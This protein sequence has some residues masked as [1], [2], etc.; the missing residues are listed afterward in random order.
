MKQSL[1]DKSKSRTSR[2]TVLTLAA[3]LL[4]AAP[5]A[6][7]LPTT[8]YTAQSKLNSDKWVK[9]KTSG[10]GIHEISY[11]TLRQWGFSNPEKVNVY[12]YGATLLAPETF[13]V[14]TPDDIKMTYTL[15]EG[16]KIYFYS[17]GDVTAELTS[18][19]YAT[20]RRNYYSTDVFYLLSDRTPDADEIPSAAAL[21]TSTTTV[22]AHLS[23]QYVEDEL[24]NP[25]LYGGVFFGKNL[26]DDGSPVDLCFETRDMGSGNTAYRT[27][28]IRAGFAVMNSRSTKLRIQP[29]SDLTVSTNNETS[30]IYYFDAYGRYRTGSTYMSYT[31]N[32]TDGV[33]NFKANI[34]TENAHYTPS[35]AAMDYTWFIYPRLSR[36][37]DD[38]QLSM[39]FPNV[40]AVQ[41]FSIAGGS[42]TTR[43][44][45]ISSLTNIRPHATSFDESTGTVTASFDRNYSANYTPAVCHIVAF[46]IDRPQK[47][48]ELVGEIANQ[49]F[50]G[51]E[52]P[53]MLIITVPEL[54]GAAEELAELHRR[55]DG[56]DV[57]VADHHAIFNEFSSATPDIMGYR[58]LIKMFY[59]RDPQ[60]FKYVIMYGTSIWDNRGIILP[61]SDRLLV[62]E[63]LDPVYSGRRTWAFA[64]DSY[65]G[66]LNDNYY[67]DN[68]INTKQDVAVGRIPV[69]NSTDGASYN[70]KVR[71]YLEDRPS[72]SVYNTVLLMSDDGDYNQHLDQSEE[73]AALL[74]SQHQPMTIVR[75]HNSIFPWD[76]TDAK[77]LRSIATA[78]FNRGAGLFIYVGH[79]NETAF[80][81]EALWNRNYTGKTVYNTFPLG[82]W[83]TCDPFA[84][85]LDNDNHGQAALL[86]EDG[87]LVAV[88]AAGRTVYAASNRPLTNSV[89]QQYAVARPGATFGEIWLNARNNLL[90]QSTEAYPDD[91]RKNTMCYNLGGDPAL[92]IASPMYGVAVTSMGGADPETAGDTDVEPLQPIEIEGCIVDSDNNIVTDFNGTVTIQL[93]DAPFTIETLVRSD[94]DTLENILLDQEMLASKTVEVTN[95]HFSATVVAPVPV[96]EGDLPNRMTFHADS[97][98]G[99][100]GDGILSSLYVRAPQEPDTELTGNAP[101]IQYMAVNGDGH[102]TDIVSH[103]ESVRLTA[104]GSVDYTGLNNSSAI[105]AGCSLTIDGKPVDGVKEIIKT[106]RDNNWTLDIA[107]PEVTQ[108]A[109]TA[110]LTIADNAGRR[111]SQA[112]TFA[113]SA[114]TEITLAA[115]ATTVRDTVTFDI[116]H[117]LGDI[118]DASLVIEDRF[119]RA[120]LNRSDITFPCQI[121]L[122][123]TDAPDGH[124]N[125]Y[126][127]IAT[128]RGLGHSQRLPLTLFRK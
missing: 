41:N 79:G 115:D 89:A 104:A 90:D 31:G 70:R 106:D 21:Y 62:Y 16:D 11:E 52:T 6:T 86:K 4:A 75:A 2:L 98:D 38:A 112:L 77:N 72:V 66:M 5:A 54:M 76:N 24:E 92:R 108:G 68:I 125:A 48:V 32:L 80:G 95:G 37:N 36:L 34:Y 15:H 81:R 103:L 67:P 88:I 1:H 40:K 13:N 42:P 83:A 128:D 3:S 85:D 116:S 9:V 84:I 111:T 30:A 47:Q 93:Y 53:D 56:M 44:F 105:G 19:T 27:S 124:Y 100:H 20:A 35:Y 61:K 82:M 73:A 65:L 121:N 28:S 7:A 71:K 33:H 12:G 51:M 39:F 57:V 97:D 26:P 120:V 78:T 113:C 94:K 63:T 122:A 14:S 118:A 18:E 58:R 96:H 43:V 64:S 49:N 91:D 60:K 50:H 101:V 59:D 119:G 46:D 74:S 114:Q 126:V 8:Y 69:S 117:D 29:P 102:P 10:E 107:L 17:T 25:T 45:N 123:D 87:G 127:R 55:F 99:R 109:H 22:D 110:V 23:L